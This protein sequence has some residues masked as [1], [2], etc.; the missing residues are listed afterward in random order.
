MALSDVSGATWRSGCWPGQFGAQLRR[1]RSCVCLCV[2]MYVQQCSRA[3]ARARGVGLHV[4]MCWRG[5]ANVNMQGRRWWPGFRGLG[6]WVVSKKRRFFAD[7]F[8]NAHTGL[9]RTAG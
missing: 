7:L 4:C 5:C 9:L 6:P 2:C 1:G 8:A 3:C